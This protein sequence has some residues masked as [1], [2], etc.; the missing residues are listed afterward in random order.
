[1]IPLPI[2]NGLYKDRSLPNS[3]QLCKN[4]YPS[5]VETQGLSQKV[6]YGTPGL[7]ERASA[8]GTNKTNRG[9]HTKEGIPYFVNGDTLYSLTRKFSSGGDNLYNLNALGTVAGTGRVSMADNGDQLIV[10]GGNVGY[11]YDESTNDWALQVT[12]EDNEWTSVTYGDSLYVA[13]SSDG[14]NRVMTSP[15]GE[16]WTARS[17]SSAESW[18]SAAYGNSAYVA[19]AQ[20]GGTGTTYAMSSSDGITWTGRS[21]SVGN[22]KGLAYGNSLFV[23]VG[24][25]GICE[26]S[27]DGTT[28]TTRTIQSENWNAV[29]YAGGQFVAVGG[30]DA[31]STSPD[32]ITWTARTGGGGSD[33]WVCIAYGNGRYVALNGIASVHRAIISNNGE[34]WDLIEVPQTAHW[35]G[36][37][38]ANGVFVAVGDLIES[39]DDQLTMYSYDGINWEHT[40]VPG[41]SRDWNAIVF[42]DE[43]VAV[44]GSAGTTS[45]Q[46]VMTSTNGG[47]PFQIITQ[48]DTDF[49]ANG[50]P[51]KVRF[52][53][54]YFAVTTDSK[55]WIRSA[56]NNGLDWTATDFGSAEADPD[57]IQAIEIDNNN[58]YIFGT[59][60]IEEF[61]NIG[62]SGFGF[63]R[64]G[65]IHD[66]GTYAPDSVIKTTSGIAFLGGGKDE[67]PARS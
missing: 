26:T 32:G 10:I 33:G 63:Q 19:V 12:P 52:V 25:S 57:D 16:T 38:Y 51:E 20:T 3:H 36:V 67:S 22:W 62:G 61:D 6:L 42:G 59:E 55:R 29:I 39:G 18:Q 31:V 2:A 44:R 17:A 54:G 50:S 8:G 48:Y 5:I 30:S 49:T 58:V 45:G 46:A 37:T 27:P 34:D 40:T 15:D 24:T 14:T 23:A 13:V 43:F 65:V 9:A 35:K 66:K 4:W 41:S 28:W 64:S 47:D 56:Q 11:L 60:T 21:I 53:D 7:V 1:M